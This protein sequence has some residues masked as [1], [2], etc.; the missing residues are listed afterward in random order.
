MHLL[1]YLPR[2]CVTLLQV[3]D[4]FLLGLLQRTMGLADFTT[5]QCLLLLLAD[6]EVLVAASL[7]EKGS[8]TTWVPRFQWMSKA[9]GSVMQ[10]AFQEGAGFSHSSSIAL[11]LESPVSKLR[12]ENYTGCVTSCSGTS[13]C[14][15]ACSSSSPLRGIERSRQ[16]SSGSLESGIDLRRQHPIQMICAPGRCSCRQLSLQDCHVWG[17]SGSR[18]PGGTLSTACLRH[19]LAPYLCHA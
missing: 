10:Q 6:M 17:C 18:S 15:H 12:R 19:R 11:T 16:R 5:E 3:D 4:I 1:R 13:E 7:N 2:P 8:S 14:L 9:G